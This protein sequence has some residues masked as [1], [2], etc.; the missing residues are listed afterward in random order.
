MWESELISSGVQLGLR[1]MV[2]LSTLETSNSFTH[3]LHVSAPNPPSA[4]VLGPESIFAP[5]PGAEV[6]FLLLLP[7]CSESSPVP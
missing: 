7:R 3:T 5:A 1:L 2:T 4:A 6:F